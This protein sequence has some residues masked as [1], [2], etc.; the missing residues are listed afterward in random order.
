LTP[1]QI[2]SVASLIPGQLKVLE[3]TGFLTRT[4]L[5]FYILAEAAFYSRGQHLGPVG[6]TIVAE[7]LIVVLR[8]STDSILVD[9]HWRPTLG[10][11]QGEF[12]FED[13]FKLARV[14]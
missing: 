6:S 5:W 8:N 3:K 9:P 1:N 7:V 11:T 4:P 14:F 13:L 12:S 2:A 10:N